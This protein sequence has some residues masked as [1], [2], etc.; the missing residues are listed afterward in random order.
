MQVY[1]LCGSSGTGKSH[2]AVTLT[3]Q[4]GISA[5]IDDGLLISGN[6]IMAGRSA[7]AESSSM[8]ATRRAIFHDAQHAAT[9]RNAIQKLAP[10]KIMVLG[11][12][13]A[14][15]RRICSALDLPEP[16]IWL[17]IA[18]IASAQEMLRAQHQ[19]IMEGTH[20]IPVAPTEVRRYIPVAL[21]E[22]FDNMWRNP[23]SESRTNERTLVKPSFN[24]GTGAIQLHLP[25]VQ[26]LIDQA[27]EEFGTHIYR[28]NGASLSQKQGGILSLDISASFQGCDF[29]LLQQVQLRVKACI[30]AATGTIPGSVELTITSM[31]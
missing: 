2:Q 26:P 27:I 13:Q 30:E 22:V 16:G 17:D 28:L 18:D 23:R 29:A 12:S 10:E 6:R 25:M 5:I 1:G 20:V 15:V 19:R 3:K 7:K 24:S 11:T 31:L 9:V 21:A 4:L 8:A 14:M